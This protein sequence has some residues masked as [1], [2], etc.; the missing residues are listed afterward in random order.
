MKRIDPASPAAFPQSVLAHPLR[1]ISWGAS[2][3][4]CPMRRAIARWER[5]LRLQKRRFRMVTEL[6]IRGSI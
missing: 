4:L 6:T 5:S 2:A 1:L 3:T